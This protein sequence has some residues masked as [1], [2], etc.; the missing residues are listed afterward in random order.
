MRYIAGSSLRFW[1]PPG[2]VH[3][4]AEILDEMSLPEAIVRQAFPLSEPGAFLSIQDSSGT[5]VGVLRSLAELDEA[6]RRAVAQDL[7]RR[8]FTPRI[9][10]ILVLKQDAG[11]WLFEVETQRGHSTFYV[12]NWRDSAHEIGIGR[13]QINSLDGQRFEIRD[14]DKLDA[15]SRR[16]LDQLG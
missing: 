9:S 2:S 8:Y 11:M 12:R 15:K 13:L 1:T 4:R 16:L 10:R 3:L 14:L 6:S 5:E 7:D